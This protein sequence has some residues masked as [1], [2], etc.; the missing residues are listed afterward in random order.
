ME[1]VKYRCEKCGYS[2]KLS[3]KNYIFYFIVSFLATTG[4]FTVIYFSYIYLSPDE[5]MI[6]LMSDVI[7]KDFTRFAAENDDE[8]REVALNLTAECDGG[9][10]LCYAQQIY[11]N[12][13]TL[14]Y[15][16]VSK[17]K[18]IYNPIYTLDSGGDC[19]NTAILVTSLMHSLGF[20][21]DVVCNT[22]HCV[23]KV[24][25]KNTWDKEYNRYVIVDLAYS[26][27]EIFNSTQ[28]FWEYYE[29]EVEE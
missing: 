13:I 2:K 21:A 9:Y 17:Y 24:P 12:L 22:E 8:I 4:G 19:K 29:N 6:G 11:Y 26:E 3:I 15:V 1:R 20:E 18:I 14:R 27:F 25:L 23:T 5:S 16:P 28:D 10:S 7:S